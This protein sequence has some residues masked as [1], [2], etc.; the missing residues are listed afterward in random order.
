M[1]GI[2]KLRMIIY[3]V[4][5]CRKCNVTYQGV[6]QRIVILIFYNFTMGSLTKDV[7]SDGERE[8][9]KTVIFLYYLLKMKGGVKSANFE[10]T[11][12][13]NGP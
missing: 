10:G 9:L 11:S 12:I 13:V 7:L 6:L 5:S 1:H 8:V 2:Y 4:T 3:F